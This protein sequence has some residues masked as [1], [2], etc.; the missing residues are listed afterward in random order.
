MSL[1]LVPATGREPSPYRPPGI[2][3]IVLETSLQAFA[4]IA[5]RAFLALAGSVA[6]ALALIVWPVVL[7]MPEDAGT[8]AGAIGRFE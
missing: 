4:M 5:I 7:R 6:P 3:S 1:Q 8:E 2:L